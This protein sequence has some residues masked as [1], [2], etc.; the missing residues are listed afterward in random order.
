[1]FAQFRIRYPQGSIITE[2]LTVD[3][4]KY[5]VR[6]LIQVDGITLATGMAAAETVELAEDRARI[7]ALAVLDISPTVASSLGS[8]SLPEPAPLTDLP[9]PKVW[10][11]NTYESPIVKSATYSLEN[12]DS[13]SAL[14]EL[15]TTPVL[16]LVDQILDSPPL[17]IPPTSEPMDIS[18][19]IDRTDVEMK[20]LGW[21]K[22]QGR[23]YIKSQYG[24]KMRAELSNQQLL[25]FL[26]YLELQPNPED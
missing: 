21:T 7:R 11:T 2:L 19:I 13:A 26:H 10:E 18:A 4:S 6:S 9:A 20:R 14:A 15:R 1:M 12:G 22:E 16:P 17:E 5:I 24:K 23:N 25:E 3:S 8:F